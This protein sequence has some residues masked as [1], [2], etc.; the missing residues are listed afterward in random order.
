MIQMY[1]VSK[2]YPNGALALQNINLYIEKGEFVFLVGPSGAGKS[3]FMKLIIRRSCQPPAR[4]LSGQKRDQTPSLGD[5]TPAA[6]RRDCL[7][8]LSPASQQNRLRKRR[9]CSRGDRGLS[10]GDRA[11]GACSTGACG[12]EST[13]SQLCPTSCPGGEQQRVSLARSIVN[14]PLIL[15][16][17]EPTGNL[18][19]DTSWEIMDLLCEINKKRHHSDHDNPQQQHCGSNEKAGNRLRKRHNRPRRPEGSILQMKLGQSSTTSRKLPAA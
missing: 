17:D 6:Q 2:R 5:S 15:L 7:S 11:Q 18:D 13:S 10:Q 4:L 9:L 8:R 12:P 14:N 3:T 19:P 16:A 1:Q